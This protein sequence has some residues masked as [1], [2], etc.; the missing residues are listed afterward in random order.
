V[1]RFLPALIVLAGLACL[2]APTLAQGGR[3]P[4]DPPLSAAERKRQWGE[5]LLLGCLAGGIGV[6]VLVRGTREFI[7]CLPKGRRYHPDDD[8]DD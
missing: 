7:A 5:L 2:P 6:T 4:A 8:D 1:P 3:S